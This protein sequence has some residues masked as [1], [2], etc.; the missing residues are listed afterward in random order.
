[1]VNQT[2]VLV[3]DLGRL[4]PVYTVARWLCHVQPC[5]PS[6]RSPKNATGHP[7]FMQQFPMDPNR[8]LSFQKSYRVR[9]TVLGRDAQAQMNVIA[10]RMPFQQLDPFLLA[11]IPQNFTYRCS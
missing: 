7:M 11:Q 6:I 10:H 4:A 9:N 3:D 2:I 1:M 5:S 8:T